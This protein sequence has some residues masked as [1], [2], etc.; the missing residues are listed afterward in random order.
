MDL[1]KVSDE[2]KVKLC[3]KYTLVGLAFLPFLWLVNAIWFF[4][5]AFCRE[6]FPGQKSM[7]S[8]VIKSFIGF[9]IW[10]AGLSTW[11]VMYQTN[12]ASWG[13]LG[14]TLSFLIPLGEP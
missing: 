3:R 2:E 10:A 14:D 12:R 5:E 11:I 9:S 1:R 7:R 6:S 8:N 13:E 4:R